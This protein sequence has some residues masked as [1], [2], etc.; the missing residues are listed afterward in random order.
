M[1]NKK[2]IIFDDEGDLLKVTQVILESR[3]F[4]VVAYDSSRNAIENIKKE[5]PDLIL[6]DIFM[7]YKDG[8]QVCDEVRCDQEIKD[9]PII[10]CT[11]QTVEK[12]LIDKAHE[13]YGAN[14]YIVKPFEIDELIEKIKKHLK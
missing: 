10:V 9:I 4:D 13:F 5:K 3:G 2:V 12:G 14:D 11:A 6:L 1:A 8:Y 7:P